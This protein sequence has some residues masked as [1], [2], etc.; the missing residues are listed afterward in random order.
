VGGCLFLLCLLLA[1]C[2]QLER[3]SPEKNFFTIEAT[4]P[5]TPAAEPHFGDLRLDALNVAPAYAMKAFVYRTGTLQYEEDYYNRFFAAPAELLS[6]ETARWL[7]ASGLFAAVYDRPAPV[8]PAWHMTGSVAALYGDFSKR[9]ATAVL[10]ISFQ[11]LH[12]QDAGGRTALRRE[13]RREIPLDGK[14]PAALAAGWSEALAQILGELEQDLQ[15][16]D[17][18]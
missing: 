2:I 9:P 10:E 17:P 8:E 12:D 7:R 18:H 1:G 16:S 14:T 15:K 13:Y 3:Q 4:R 5:G 11:L 6:A